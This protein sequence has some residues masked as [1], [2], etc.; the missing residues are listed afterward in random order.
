MESRIKGVNHPGLV[1]ELKELCGRKKPARK[2]E[3]QFS[4]WQYFGKSRNTFITLEI[5]A[6]TK[7]IVEES[8][9]F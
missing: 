7:T 9:K 6:P 4:Q 8:E 3:A 5:S 2:K 1:F